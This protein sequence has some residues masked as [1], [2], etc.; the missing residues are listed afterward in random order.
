M[1]R[2][3]KLILFLWASAMVLVGM[4]AIIDWDSLEQKRVQKQITQTLGEQQNVLEVLVTGFSKEA[5]IDLTATPFLYRVFT[6]GELIKWSDNKTLPPYSQLRKQDSIYYL[7]HA[8][9]KYIVQRRAV[10]SEEDI[11]DFFSVLRLEENFQIANNFLQDIVNPN[12]FKQSPKEILKNTNFPILYN[13]EVLFGITPSGSAKATLLAVS[14]WILLLSLPIGIGATLIKFRKHLEAG[15]FFLGFIFGLVVIRLALLMANFPGRWLEI[16]IFDGIVY[17]SS[18][19][20]SDLGNTLIN[21]SFLALIAG[22]IGYRLK[23]FSGQTSAWKR[24]L[25][26][27]FAIVLVYLNIEFFFWIS[28]DLMEH[29]QI[30]FDITDSI[31]FDFTRVVAFLIILFSAVFY[32]LINHI[33]VRWISLSKPSGG[34]YLLFHLVVLAGFIKFQPD[35]FPILVLQFTWYWIMYLADF[36]LQFAVVKKVALEYVLSIG[37]LLALVFA[38]SIFQFH[39]N[40]E[41]ESKARFANQLVLEKDVLGEFYL[42]E[43]INGFRE[44]ELIPE[45][46][47]GGVFARQNVREKIT[48]EFISSYFDKYELNIFLFN[49]DGRQLDDD[50]ESYGDFQKKYEKSEFATDYNSIYLV[51][52]AQNISLKKYACFLK[53]EDAGAMVIELSR[54]KNIPASVFP[55]L[56]VESKYEQ[57]GNNLFDYSIFK[58]STVLYGQGKFG[59]TNFLTGSDLGN[60]KLYT[61]GISKDG[62]NFFGLK[63]EDGRIITI[64]SASYPNRSWAI[65]FSFIFL[66]FI[67][68]TSMVGI[69]YRLALDYQTLS[70]ANKI[71]LYLALGFLIPLFVTGFTLLNTL[72]E[73]YKEE[74][75]RSYL[76]KSLRISEN[77]VDE[78]ILYTGNASDQ[79]T[80]ANYIGDVSGFVEA[81]LIIYTADG[82]MITTSQPGVFR[83]GLLSDH[84]NPVALQALTSNNQNILIDESIGLLDFKT[85]YTA[86]TGDSDGQLLGIVALPFFDSK[87]HLRRQQKEVFADLLMIFALIFL[88]ALISGNYVLNYLIGPLKIVSDHIKRTTLEVDNQPIDYSSDDEIGVLVK[89]YNQMLVKL[90]RNKEALARSQKES[91][92]KEIARQV[93]HEIKN[94]LTP[95]RLKIQ[96]LQRDLSDERQIKLLTSMVAQIDT[97]SDIADSFSEFAKMPAPENVEF[98]V[99]TAVAQSIQLHRS[100]QVSITTE[101]PSGPVTIWADPNILGRIMNNLLLNAIQ[102]VKDGRVELCVRVKLDENKVEISCE[103]NGSGI[104]DEIKEKI[105]T[106]Y[107]STKVTGSGIGLAVAKKGIENAGGNIWFESKEGVGTTFYISL[108][109]YKAI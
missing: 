70:L 103:D 76:K 100:K 107:F 55:E 60:E 95:M 61:K 66:L 26:L 42:N 16:P 15:W 57:Q 83:L 29:S 23:Y 58:D 67:L 73:S 5:G 96:Q 44:D 91:A 86:I 34:F 75:T 88:A 37:G 68:L 77:L 25:G 97:L 84:I 13:G 98:D 22:I 41:M 54:K 52:D 45:R 63:T 108:P 85:T 78:N 48:R 24:V 74:I 109:I 106:T 56:L 89:E 1:K 101:L 20:N 93:A 65:N 4:Y 40:R 8:S 105:F 69:L 51:D 81:D 39:Q 30:K 28:H 14:I 99:V 104:P 17:S 53:L 18:F 32:F 47:T 43:I 2:V 102:S 46:I 36:S 31:Q 9:G 33:L 7:E 59:H 82:Q 71:Q 94:P 27:F 50:E 62:K 10:Q 12:V 49:P 35:L 3:L 38:F 87:N 90:D 6:N 19:L 92:W 11:T 21:L 79:N 72:N 80:F 64:A